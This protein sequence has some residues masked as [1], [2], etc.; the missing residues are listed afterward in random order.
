MN[1]ANIT[2]YQIFGT[3]A[4]F[5][6]DVYLGVTPANSSTPGGVRQFIYSG[7]LTAS[8]DTSNP[9]MPGSRGTSPFISANGSSDGIVWVIDQGNPLQ[10][11]SGAAP[12][13]ATLRAYDA[14]KY[15]KEIYDSGMN[16]GDAAGYGIKFSSPVV[17]NGKVYIATGHDLTTVANPQGEVDVYGLK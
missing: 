7:K 3:S 12:S 1:Y 6:G 17:A 9:Q 11:S 2:S 16:A 15:P 5:N 14:A 13:S 8:S 4:A 10:N